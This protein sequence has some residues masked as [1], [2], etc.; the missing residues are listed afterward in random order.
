VYRAGVSFHVLL[1][2]F[3]RRIEV[4]RHADDAFWKHPR[5]G[6]LLNLPGLLADNPRDGLLIFGDD[7]F[8]SGG[9]PVD[10]ILEIRLCFINRDD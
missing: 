10:D 8:I 9:Q 1:E 7:D 6:T 2:F 5:S 4:R 3:Q